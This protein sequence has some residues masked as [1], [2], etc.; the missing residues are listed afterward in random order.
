MDN[1]LRKRDVEGASLDIR[2]EERTLEHFRHISY[3]TE[4]TRRLVLVYGSQ[5]EN[6]EESQTPVC[7]T[8]LRDFPEIVGEFGRVR[9]QDDDS[10]GSSDERY[11]RARLLSSASLM[12]ASIFEFSS[13]LSYVKDRDRFISTINIVVFENV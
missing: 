4:R 2:R 5:N 7:P 9:R 12:P 10:R 8:W 13:E 6:V 1:G 3:K 11:S